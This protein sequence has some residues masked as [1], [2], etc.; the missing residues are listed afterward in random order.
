MSEKPSGAS[1]D[2]MSHVAKVITLVTM[3]TN[4]E[5]RN[6]KSSG[7][8]YKNAFD[9]RSTASFVLACGL[10]GLEFLLKM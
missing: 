6:N 7:V 8:I 5:V 4:P 10:V 3:A 1:M 9:S 2:L